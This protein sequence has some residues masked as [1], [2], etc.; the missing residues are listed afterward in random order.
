[1]FV[2]LAIIGYASHFSHPNIP[3]LQH[4]LNKFGWPEMM[5]Y[6]GDCYYPGHRVKL[7]YL[8]KALPEL[9]QKGY[10]HFIALDVFDTLCFNYMFDFKWI[11]NINLMLS[12]ELACWP[13][14]SLEPKYQHSPNKSLWKHIN[15]GGILG[16]ILYTMYMMDTNPIDHFEDDQLYW[17]HVYLNH[18][19]SYTPVFSDHKCMLFQTTAHCNPW[20]RFFSY[21]GENI[22]NNMLGSKP[23]FW[24]ANGGSEMAWMVEHLDRKV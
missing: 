14:P 6:G 18:K 16:N 11:E 19:D 21:E 12:T 1:M 5:L 7:E 2:K 8:K 3:L 13:D 23:A 4:S 24:H 17:T 9:D 20:E 22:V 15:S 10:T